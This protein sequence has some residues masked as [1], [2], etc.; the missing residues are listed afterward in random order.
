MSNMFRTVA[1]ARCIFT[2]PNRSCYICATSL[3]VSYACTDYHMTCDTMSVSIV[4][5]IK[6]LQHI[7]RFRHMP[8]AL[9]L[10]PSRNIPMKPKSLLPLY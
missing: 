1:Q 5:Q 8:A 4:P 2:T 7:P 6:D 9:L 3:N 10:L